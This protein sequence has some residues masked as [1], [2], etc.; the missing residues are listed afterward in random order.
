MVDKEQQLRLQH[1]LTHGRRLKRTV[2]KPASRAPGSFVLGPVGRPHH[3]R[4]LAAGIYVHMHIHACACLYMSVHSEY[5][6]TTPAPYEAR[7]FVQLH[8]LTEKW[9]VHVRTHTHAHMH[10]CGHTQ[11]WCFVFV[12][13]GFVGR[14]SSRP[15]RQRRSWQRSVVSKSWY[16]KLRFSSALFLD[17]ALI[18][19][20]KQHKAI[21]SPEGGILFIHSIY[22]LFVYLFV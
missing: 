14:H 15:W 12:G 6:P 9:D 16:E 10:A 8:V 20:T 17:T 5:T 18:F 3:A 2:S 1:R 22:C 13:C 11:C 21:C 19:Q 4:Q 7:S